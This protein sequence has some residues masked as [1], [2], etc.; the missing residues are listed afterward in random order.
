MAIQDSDLFIVSR[1]GANYTVPAATS[2]AIEDTDLL[3]VSRA[4][5]NYKVT[6]QEFKDYAGGPPLGESTEINPGGLDLFGFGWALAD[7]LWS[8]PGSVLIMMRAYT[9]ADK[10]ASNTYFAKTT[11][12]GDTW[13]TAPVDYQSLETNGKLVAYYEPQSLYYRVTRGGGDGIL[14]SSPDGLNWTTV[15]TAFPGDSSAL[16]LISLGIK[17]GKFYR[18]GFYSNNGGVTMDIYCVYVD[19]SKVSTDL[20][21]KG[22]R[23]TYIWDF[24]YAEVDP[25]NATLYYVNNPNGTPPS[26]R[27]EV[28]GAI[29]GNNFTREAALQGT[30]T[31]RWHN[32]CAFGA[33]SDGYMW[34]TSSSGHVSSKCPIK[35]TSNYVIADFSRPYMLGVTE[36][37]TTVAT[38][39]MKTWIYTHLP[40]W[41]YETG[42]ASGV[43][44]DG[45]HF[46]IFGRDSVSG[47]SKIYRIS[48]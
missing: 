12:A 20:W 10:Q 39:D 33:M 13:T 2:M 42:K 43:A 36:N 48:Y 3:L 6:G 4:G 25:Y 46:L 22:G 18:F 35:G 14:Y 1:D 19:V 9:Q 21:T 38:T 23:G 27:A 7:V 24:L 44:T 37:G 15:P 34:K 30:A 26:Q 29:N 8:N 31:M 11:D 47:L 28:T 17:G 5:A 45:S 16:G 40:G 41:S 32:G